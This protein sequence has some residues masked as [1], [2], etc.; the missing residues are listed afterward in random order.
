MLCRSCRDSLLGIAMRDEVATCGRPP[1]R[2]VRM[3]A[4]SFSRSPSR[5]IER[6]KSRGRGRMRS[7]GRDGVRSPRHGR[8]RSPSSGRVR[9]PKRG[10]GHSP[11]RGRV[12]TR[13]SRRSLQSPRS[14]LRSASPA[15]V[16]SGKRPRCGSGADEQSFHSMQRAPGPHDRTLDPADRALNPADAAY[17]PEAHA[18]ARAG[19]CAR[20]ALV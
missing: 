4:R 12:R 13:S 8:T 10:H 3:R 17:D 7:P 18:A 14:R 16:H 6:E 1:S 9:S 5:G 19:T 11:C 2:R 20:G 15:V